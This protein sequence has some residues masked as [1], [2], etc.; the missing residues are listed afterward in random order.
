MD[1]PSRKPPRSLP[2]RPSGPYLLPKSDFAMEKWSFS[3]RYLIANYLLAICL[4]TFLSPCLPISL[5]VDL[6]VYLPDFL[7]IHLPIYLPPCLS[8]YLFDQA[9][10]V[11]KNT[12]NDVNETTSLRYN[13]LSSVQQGDKNEKREMIARTRTSISFGST[14]N[15]WCNLIR[16]IREEEEDEEETLNVELVRN[17]NVQTRRVFSNIS[18]RNQY[19]S[20]II[21]QSLRFEPIWCADQVWDRWVNRWRNNW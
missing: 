5:F 16:E 19:R 20:H 2:R 1:P 4:S 7:S 12:M 11:V 21:L 18:L 10:D 3:W 13:R 6:F 14:T 8:V 17:R 9:E 15:D